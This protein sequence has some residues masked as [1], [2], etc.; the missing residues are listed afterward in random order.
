MG[1][2]IAGAPKTWDCVRH[3]VSLL[4]PFLTRSS[5][6][7]PGSQH[8]KTLSR[9]NTSCRRPRACLL[10]AHPLSP[11]AFC[12]TT[13][14]TAAGVD[15]GFGR[16]V[17]NGLPIQRLASFWPTGAP[18]IP[19]PPA[20]NSKTLDGLRTSGGRTVPSGMPPLTARPQTGFTGFT[21]FYT[22]GNRR[23]CA[24]ALSSF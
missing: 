1:P 23:S 24:A 11:G 22:L 14:G 12:A 7:P 16:R 18:S 9:G 15:T 17:S 4:T 20:Q 5:G 6:P 13:S 19:R 21:S 10:Q 3:A 8:P 2:A